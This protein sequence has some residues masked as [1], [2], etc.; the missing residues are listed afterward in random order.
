MAVKILVEGRPGAGKTTVAVRLADLLAERGV[1]LGGFVTHEMRERGRRVGFAVETMGGKRATLAHVS[2][3]GPP[4]VGRYGVDVDAFERLALPT[5]EKAPPRGVV[6]VDE[7]GKMEL[8]SHGFRE[9]LVRLL[10]GPAGVVATIHVFGD[11]FTDAIKRR[12]DVER[13]PLTRATR[14]ELPAQLA[15]KLTTA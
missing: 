15:D 5:L 7:I 3:L 12:R 11:P 8:A 14:A 1:E 4:R 6:V 10:D 9:A 13:L 2:L